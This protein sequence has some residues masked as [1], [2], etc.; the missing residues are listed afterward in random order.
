LLRFCRLSIYYL[1]IG[2]VGH[3]CAGLR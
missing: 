1:F 3:R 2:V